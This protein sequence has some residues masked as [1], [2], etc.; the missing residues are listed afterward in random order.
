TL[1]AGNRSPSWSERIS[2]HHKIIGDGAAL[3]VI[4][5]APRPFGDHLTFLE[6]VFGGIAVDEKG[7]RAFA[8]GGERFESTIAVGI[9]VTHQDDFAFD[10]DALLAEKFV[11]FGI[12]AVG[13]DE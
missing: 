6:P 2:G 1:G 5:G 11:V 8:L 4:L 10:V 9:R 13:V 12:A 3:D 7:G